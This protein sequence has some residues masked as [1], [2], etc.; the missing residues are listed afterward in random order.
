MFR[1][2]TENLGWKLFSL[3]VATM[4]WYF[5]ASDEIVLTSVNSP[6]QLRG[7]PA[8]LEISSDLPSNIRLE[9]SG[10]SRKLNEL[11]PNN[12]VVNVDL[13][14]L[15]QPSVQT[16]TISASNLRLPP[17][18]TLARSVPSQ[19]RIELERRMQRQVPVKPQLVGQLPEGLVLRSAT[20]DPPSIMVTGPRSF[21]EA[22]Q[23]ASTS[24]IDLSQIH[25]SQKVQVYSVIDEPQVRVLGRQTAIVF[26]EVGPRQ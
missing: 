3:L 19:V 14:T 10:P 2:I 26:V 11:R 1:A 12:T 13:G 23:D 21:V 17:G 7:M 22:V 6:I 5:V 4:L 8:D 18:V 20:V 15:T 25:G 9:L 16:V 24:V